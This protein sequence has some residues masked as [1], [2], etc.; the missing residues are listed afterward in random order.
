MAFSATMDNET[1]QVCQDFVHRKGA[2]DPPD[3]SIKVYPKNAE[4]ANIQA[5]MKQTLYHNVRK[6]HIQFSD[7]PQFRDR[8]LQ[9]QVYQRLVELL[10]MSFQDQA[11]A[12]AEPLEGDEAE[13]DVV[14]VFDQQCIA[15]FPNQRECVAARK[16]L[17]AAHVES[18]TTCGKPGVF[19]YW[20]SGA[21][22]HPRDQIPLP[23]TLEEVRCHL[24]IECYV[25]ILP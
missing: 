15:F 10:M 2:T 6:V 12:S 8:R 21:R 11:R 16:T 4:V 14:K 3:A 23:Q 9:N 22:V 5:E 18:A 19:K 1:I 20:A 7:E 13:S 17:K 24:C 25:F